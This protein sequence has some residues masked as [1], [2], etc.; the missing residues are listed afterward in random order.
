MRLLSLAILF[1]LGLVF[2]CKEEP[3]PEDIVGQQAKAY[4]DHLFAGRYDQYVAGIHDID[5]L[6]AAYR[7]QLHVGARQFA[8]RQQREHA[9][10]S[11]VIVA[12]AV[13]DTA[14]HQA[15]AFLVLCYGDSTREEIVV[16][17]AERLP[18]QWR[19]K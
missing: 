18:G 3:R 2:S 12:R 15:R 13:V 1:S 7:E 5:S 17:M 8:A 14:A 10:V 19:M 4:Y 16:P 9:G 11:E 6:P